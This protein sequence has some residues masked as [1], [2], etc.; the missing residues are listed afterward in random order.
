MCEHTRVPGCGAR[1]GGGGQL[2]QPPADPASA[3]LSSTTRRSWTCSTAPATPTPATANPTSKSTR[4]PAGASTPRG[5]RRASSARR[6]RWVRDGA[7]L[8]G[9][10]GQPGTCYVG[11]ARR[12]GGLAQNG[13]EQPRG[14]AGRGRCAAGLWQGA[15]LAPWEGASRSC[16]SLPRVVVA[17]PVPKTGGSFPHHCQHPDE[18]AEL[19][20]PRHLHHSPLPDESVC[21]PGAGEMSSCLAAGLFLHLTPRRCVGVPWKGERV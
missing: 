4:M 10:G 9:L 1:P 21:P 3:P 7:D 6:T 20:V 18:R 15:A 12:G 17:D 8:E 5:S 14:D 19:P 11:T 2:L 16:P 13:A